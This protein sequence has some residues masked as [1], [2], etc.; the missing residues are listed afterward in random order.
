MSHKYK[1]NC[2]FKKVYH[3]YCRLCY[4][5]VIKIFIQ[6]EISTDHDIINCSCVEHIMQKVN[7]IKI[8]DKPIIKKKVKFKK[9]KPKPIP[10][11]KFISDSDDDEHMVKCVYI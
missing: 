5:P 6:Q 10:K 11:V 8:Q 1:H 2:S 7:E 4:A 9:S 3:D